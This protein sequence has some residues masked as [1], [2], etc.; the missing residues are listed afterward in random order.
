MYRTLPGCAVEPVGIAHWPPLV[1]MQGDLVPAAFI[2]A[3]EGYFV[4][5]GA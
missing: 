2:A 5:S 3:Y 1:R 4:K